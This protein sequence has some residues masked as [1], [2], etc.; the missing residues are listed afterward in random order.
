MHRIL[1]LHGP[2]LNALGVREPEIYGSVRLE[3]VDDRLRALAKEL[4]CAI[5]TRQT[6]HEGVLLDALYGAAGSSEGVLLNP[7]GLTHTS[8]SLRD[9]VR[10]IPLPV[11][12]VHLSNPRS[13]ES[14]R[15]VSFVSEAAVGIV[16]GFGADSYLLGLRALEGYLR[17]GSQA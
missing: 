10:A 6:Q 7:G 2:N 5:E 13:R 1:V 4:G 12:E 9:A 8:V 3:D 17:R 14:F 11:V 16:Q 15:R